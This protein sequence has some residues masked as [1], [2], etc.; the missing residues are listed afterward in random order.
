MLEQ[1]HPHQ[2][3]HPSIIVWSIAN[4]LN[5]A[6][7]PSQG[8]TSP[9][10][11]SAHRLDPTRPVGL[12]VAA[13]PE[14][15]ASARYAPLDVIGFNE[16]FGWYPG[17]D[18]TMADPDAALRL[19]RHGAR[20]ATRTRR[21]SSPSSAPR[22]TATGPAEEKG[23][24]A[25]PAGLRQLPPRRLRDQAVAVGRD[26]LGAAGVPRAPDLGRRQPAARPAVPPE[27]PDHEGRRQEARVLRRCSGSSTATQQFGGAD[28]GRYHPAPHMAKA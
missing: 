27:G 18:G 28:A 4:E 10:R 21:S 13:L 7:G 26:L 1:E 14:R 9:R 17:P 22:P 24:Y 5:A 3:H 16:Y 6:V 12:A 11:R 2:R 19:P 8:A 25:V 23:T 15:P 20:A